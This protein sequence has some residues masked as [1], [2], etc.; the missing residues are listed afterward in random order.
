MKH[1]AMKLMVYKTILL[2]TK[3]VILTHTLPRNLVSLRN[4]HCLHILQFVCGGLR[5][6][7]G[8]TR[9]LR[10]VGEEWHIW[11][12]ISGSSLAVW[13]SNFPPLPLHVP[14]W[15]GVAGDR[16]M[17]WWCPC[18]GSQQPRLGMGLSF[19]LRRVGVTRSG[20]LARAW[21]RKQHLACQHGW[22]QESLPP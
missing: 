17:W 13:Q 4:F 21:I 7:F 9:G 10:V 12:A 1:R 20:P 19:R 2:E 11:V 16:M 3:P 5:Q 22:N 6:G 14:H 15:M 8:C 18:E